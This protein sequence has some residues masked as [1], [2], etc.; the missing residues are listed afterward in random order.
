MVLKS[1]SIFPKELEIVWAIIAFQ[2]D[3]IIFISLE[4]V[5]FSQL[6]RKIYDLKTFN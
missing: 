1:V 3:E 2:I 5:L 6:L 4:C